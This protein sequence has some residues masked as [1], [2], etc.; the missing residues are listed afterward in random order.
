LNG[1]PD[2][3]KT[4]SGGVEY[5]E[6]DVKAIIL[7]ALYN[8]P[9]SDEIIQALFL[10]GSVLGDVYGLLIEKGYGEFYEAAFE[11][12]EKTEHDY[13]AERV[14]DRVLL[15]YEDFVDEMKMKPPEKIIDEAYKISIM[16]D[17]YISLDPCTSNFSTEQL[18][19]LH[20]LD[21]PL[22]ELYNE[23]QRRDFT[24][25]DDIKDVITDVADEQTGENQ[26][27]DF[28]DEDELEDGYEP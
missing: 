17:L 13:L 5:S 8:A 26:D 12:I 19:A 21:S 20:S 4:K 1:L 27:M 11:Y 25:M 24:H 28:E 7:E 22:W 18:R 3:A 2:D 9:M 23:W 10:Q 14:F 6:Y 15:E 16:Y